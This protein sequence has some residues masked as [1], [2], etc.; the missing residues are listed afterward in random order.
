MPIIEVSSST[1]DISQITV[2]YNLNS[3]IY[4]VMTKCLIVEENV[5][6]ADGG[7]ALLSIT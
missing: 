1:K 6:A 5:E 3:I 2:S 4:L 7:E